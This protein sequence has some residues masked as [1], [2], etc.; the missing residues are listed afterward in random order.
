MKI[1]KLLYDKAE[2]VLPYEEILDNIIFGK[3]T[4]AQALLNPIIQDVKDQYLEYF[5]EFWQFGL[6]DL[7]QLSLL[8]E[9]E[10]K[11][12]R[13]CY[14]VKTKAIDELKEKVFK[15]N[16]IELKG[17]C[18][19]CNILKPTTID[20]FLP[21][22]EFP[23]FSVL[24]LNLFPCCTTCNSKKG[25]YWKDFDRSAK[26]ILGI[27]NFFQT[28]LSNIV[29]LKLDVNFQNNIPL[30]K[31][32][33]DSPEE[34]SNSIYQTINL[35]F[36]RLNLLE[37]YEEEVPSEISELVAQ[38]RVHCKKKSKTKIKKRIKKDAARMAETY[39]INYW[40]TVIRVT[41]YNDDTLFNY[42]YFEAVK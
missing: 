32:K 24:G 9:D 36:K 27:L 17:L 8:S 7:I 14:S 4:K 20:H 6:K 29:V 33:L 19:Y 30:F 39:G 25:E 22:E 1:R 42:V 34:I 26:T 16:S 21:K 5:T 12:L 23:E 10:K 13:N 3:Q 2:G 15:N 40:K 38:L 41:I 11:G 18:P 35:H 31:F 28:D 37:R